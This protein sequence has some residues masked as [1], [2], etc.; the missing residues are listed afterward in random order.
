MLTIEEY[1]EKRKQEDKLNE[2]DLDK[3]LENIKSCVDYI[4]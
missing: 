3:R 1:I 4:L 2:F